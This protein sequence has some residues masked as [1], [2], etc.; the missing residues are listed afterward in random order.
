MAELAEPGISTIA[1][2]RARVGLEAARLLLAR[3]DGSE[4]PQQRVVLPTA[5]VRR[6]S[7]EIAA[8]A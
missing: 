3:L 6:G 1:Q 5:L 2:D 8:P 7:G 4:Q